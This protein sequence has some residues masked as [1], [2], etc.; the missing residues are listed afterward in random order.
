MDKIFEEAFDRLMEYEGGYSDHEA[1]SGG[2]TNFGITEYAARKYGFEGDMKD[3]T[4]EKA[5]EIAY[6]AYW[7]KPGINKIKDR[8]IAME[9]FEQGFNFGVA[10]AV[11]RLQKAYNLL[12]GDSITEDGII[13]TE[14]LSHINNYKFPDAL[15]NELNILQGKEYN[16]IVQSDESQ[17]VFLRGWLKR[18]TII[19]E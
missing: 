8:Y 1:D 6:F 19:K 16:E 13:G 4:R 9:V 15:Y 2:K 5:K 17:R 18:I 10:E 14:T 7:K 12:S 3:L 11:E